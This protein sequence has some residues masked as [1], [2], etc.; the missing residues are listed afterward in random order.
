[1]RECYKKLKRKSI[2][3]QKEIKEIKKTDSSIILNNRDTMSLEL[4]KIH[5]KLISK[6]IKGI[7]L[8]NKIFSF[9]QKYKVEIKEPLL[10]SKSLICLEKEDIEIKMVAGDILV[11]VEESFFKENLENLN[12]KIIKILKKIKKQYKKTIKTIKKL[13]KEKNESK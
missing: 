8:N 10:I 12:K 6:I 9:K 3:I 11:C 2:I 5:K 1:M 7:K 4:Y 13:C